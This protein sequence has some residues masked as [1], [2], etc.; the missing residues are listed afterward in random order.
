MPVA[1]RRHLG[2][3]VAERHTAMQA[4]DAAAVRAFHAAGGAVLVA[5]GESHSLEQL[6]ELAQAGLD[7]MEVYNLHANIDPKIRGPYLGLDPVGALVGLVP[8]LAGR[9]VSEGGLSRISPSWAFWPQRRAAGQFD[10][11]LAAGH[12]LAPVLGSDIHENTLKDP[13]ADGERGDG[14]RRLMRWFGNHLLVP[15]PGKAPDQR[16]PARGGVGR[17]QLRRL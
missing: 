9:P 1:L 10:T 17:P 7:G 8:W 14:Y 16:S 3:T 6:T 4:G 11:L 12:H 13:L 15:A 5:H 2:A